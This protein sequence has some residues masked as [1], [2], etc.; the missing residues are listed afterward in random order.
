[1]VQLALN[2]RVFSIA[3][4][5]DTRRVWQGYRTSDSWTSLSLR[6]VSV[7]MNPDAPPH[8]RKDTVA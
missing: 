8:Y 4:H 7:S 2:W 3:K 1:M 5:V 6:S